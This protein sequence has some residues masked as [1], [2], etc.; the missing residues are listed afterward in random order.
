M[1]N[2]AIYFSTNPIRLGGLGIIFHCDKTIMTYKVKSH[3]EE[4]YETKSMPWCW[5]ILQLLRPWVSC[6]V[7]NKTKRTLLPIIAGVV[8]D[9]SIIHTDEFSSYRTLG[10]V[11]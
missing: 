3:R 2:I 11:K 7:Q 1:E 10:N 5:L 4:G 6:H 9:G 8:R